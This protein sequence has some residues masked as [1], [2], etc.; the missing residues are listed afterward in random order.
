MEALQQKSRK[1]VVTNP[2]TRR[3]R[4]N[5]SCRQGL[6]YTDVSYYKYSLLYNAG[7]INTT[8]R[9]LA[10]SYNDAASLQSNGTIEFEGYSAYVAS[11]VMSISAMIYGKKESVPVQYKQTLTKV[12][13]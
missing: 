12:Q 6:T 13:Y 7:D 1:G 3:F 11:G 8:V 2:F 9:I 5:G 4:K 10:M